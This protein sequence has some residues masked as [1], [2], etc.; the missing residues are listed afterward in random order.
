[1]HNCNAD[2][3]ARPLILRLPRLGCINFC[4][5]SHLEIS[6][7]HSAIG[8]LTHKSARSFVKALRCIKTPQLCSLQIEATLG[9][10]KAPFH[11]DIRHGDL[12]GS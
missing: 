2:S 8:L 7:C 3:D 5:K 4:D 11:A 12:L 1:M 6:S 9:I 10:R